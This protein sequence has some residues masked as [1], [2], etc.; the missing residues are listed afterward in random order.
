VLGVDSELV[1]RGMNVVSSSAELMEFEFHYPDLA[2]A[3]RQ[4]ADKG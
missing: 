2:S 1:L 3:L 4:L